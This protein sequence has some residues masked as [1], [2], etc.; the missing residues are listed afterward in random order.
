[1]ANIK[2]IKFYTI[3]HDF[4]INPNPFF[5]YCSLGHCKSEIRRVVAK[6]VLKNNANGKADDLGIWIVGVAS[7]HNKEFKKD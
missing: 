7:G 6:D 1:M 4:G 5:G 2:Q 3:D